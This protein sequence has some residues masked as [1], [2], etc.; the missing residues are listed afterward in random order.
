[1]FPPTCINIAFMV[2]HSGNFVCSKKKTVKLVPLVISFCSQVM[3]HF[4][5]E[6]CT[7]Q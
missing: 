4:P 5:S 1:V 2:L 6:N 7:I 3:Q